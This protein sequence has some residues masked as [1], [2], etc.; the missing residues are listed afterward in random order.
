MHLSDEDLL[1]LD[2]A[3]LGTLVPALAR[4][5]GEDGG[6]PQAPTLAVGEEPVEQFMSAEV[7]RVM[8]KG[9]T[10]RAKTRP[11]PPRRRR[12]RRET[13]CPRIPDRRLVQPY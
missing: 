8:L 7:A 9:S 11:R 10:R 3:Y 6:R 1:Q 2:D 12:L 13:R 4:P 5:A